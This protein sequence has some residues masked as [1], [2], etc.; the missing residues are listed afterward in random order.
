MRPLFTC[1]AC[2]FKCNKKSNYRA[3]LSTTKHARN[4][5]ATPSAAHG[6]KELVVAGCPDQT[7][8]KYTCHLCGKA[9]KSRS[10]IWY[11][12]KNAK[13]GAPTE[14]I[15]ALPAADQDEVLSAFMEQTNKLIDDNNKLRATVERILRVEGGTGRGV[16]SRSHVTNNTF[17]TLYSETKT[18]NLNLFLNET[19]KDAMNIMDFVKSIQIQISDLNSIGTKGYVNGLTRI[20]VNS[21]NSLDETK[22]PL[23]CTDRKREIVYIKDSDKWE[24]ENDNREKLTL[25][26]NHVSHKNIQTLPKWKL[27]NPNYADSRSIESDTYQQLLIETLGCGNSKTSTSEMNHKIIKN[28][29]KEVGIDK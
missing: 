6:A 18:F 2:A 22:R 4:T 24:R 19:C 10:S 13:C 25:M 15:S 26:I 8:S 20:I 1:D 12:T 21:L 11:H 27:A 9:Y 14:I 3:H 29:I 5:R 28:V 7:E 23:H 16:K 17:N